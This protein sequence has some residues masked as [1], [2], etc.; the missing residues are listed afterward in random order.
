MKTKLLVVM[1]LLCG[2]AFARTRFSIG[3]NLG[4]YPGYAAGGYYVA[5]PPPPPPAYYA[6]PSPGPGYAF[7]AGSYYPVGARYEYRQGYWTRPP[8][9]HAVWVGPRY[10]RNRFYAGYW[11]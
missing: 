2:S 8:R 7:V 5:A 11:R 10:S 3:V 9:P 1:V 6:P 4:G